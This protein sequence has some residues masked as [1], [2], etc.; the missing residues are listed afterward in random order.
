VSQ[1]RDTVQAWSVRTEALIVLIG[2]FGLALL[3]TVVYLTSDEPIA[4]ITESELRSLLIYESVTFLLLGGFLYLRGWTFKRIGLALKLAD[5]FIGVGLA[6]GVYLVFT[7][8]WK[9]A[10]AA[11]LQ[12]AYLHG[13]SFHSAVKTR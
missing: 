4:A 2:A 12:P 7:A 5:P 11:H 9:L 8:L 10:T 3:S 1:L 6:I 13:A